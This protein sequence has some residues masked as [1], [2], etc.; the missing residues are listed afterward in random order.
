MFITSSAMEPKSLSRAIP[1][2]TISTTSWF[3]R[4]SQIPSQAKTM[5]SSSS[6]I[7]LSKRSGSA[8][9]TCC[10]AGRSLFCLNSKSPNARESAKLPL[11][12]PHST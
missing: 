2:L 10:S 12:R 3:V 5:N 9:T 6:P 7:F 11:T 4:T 1:N 8:V